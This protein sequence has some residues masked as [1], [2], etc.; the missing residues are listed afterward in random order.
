MQ[1]VVADL[2]KVEFDDPLRANSKIDAE[3]DLD[4]FQFSSGSRRRS[5]NEAGCFSREWAVFSGSLMQKFSYNNKI[6]ISSVSLPQ[7]LFHSPWFSYHR[8]ILK[9]RR[10]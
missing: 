3:S 1:V 10:T 9:I 7:I 5:S 6:P 2:E 4:G 8:T